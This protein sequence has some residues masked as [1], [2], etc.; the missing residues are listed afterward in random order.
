MRKLV[1]EQVLMRIFV[2]ED[3]KEGGRPLYTALVEMLRE[4]GIAGATVLKGTMGFGAKRHLHSGHVLSLSMDLPIVIEVVD[5]REHIDRVLPRID[6]MI[7]QGLVTLEKVNVIRYAP[8][9]DAE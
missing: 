2:G 4:E 7:A 3:D 9:L 5:T 1:G 6:E 8:R